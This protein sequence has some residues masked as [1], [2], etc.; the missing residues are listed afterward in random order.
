MKSDVNPISEARRIFREEGLFYFSYRA[1]LFLYKELLLVAYRFV[2]WLAGRRID[3]PFTL[4]YTGR[5]RV[6]GAVDGVP[7]FEF[8]YSLNRPHI[9]H[10]VLGEFET[11]V[12]RTLVDHWDEETTF[13]EV[14][15]GWGYHSLSAAPIVDRVVAFDP[16]GDRTSLL[17]RS[18]ETNGFDN[19]SVVSEAVDSLDDYLPE[20]SY[21]DVVLMDIDGWEYDVLPMST[22][23]LAAGPVW[24]VEVHHD[25]DVPPARRSDPEDVTALFERHG[26]TVERIREHYQ[27]DL[28]GNELDELNTHHVLAYPTDE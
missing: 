2:D 14:G 17:E 4:G 27:R 9:R 20:H 22:E 16:D 3:H 7:E 10:R 13:W 1:G 23:L 24:I 8:W 15:S 26:Y 21:P 19:V 25:V 6:D 5:Y 28:R 12:A 18:I 11:E